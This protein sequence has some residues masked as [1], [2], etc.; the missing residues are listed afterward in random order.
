ME[1]KRFDK[2]VKAI[3]DE[4]EESKRTNAP[5]PVVEKLEWLMF[6][7]EQLSNIEGETL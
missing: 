2:L 4:L 6:Q 7:A 1:D 5:L 3:W